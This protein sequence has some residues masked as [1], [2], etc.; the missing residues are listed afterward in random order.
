MVATDSTNPANEQPE[1]D[2]PFADV[3]PLFRAWQEGV[4]EL[5]A[6]R[7]SVPPPTP[8]LPQT[9]YD[10]ARGLADGATIKV[11]EQ[12]RVLRE[13]RE[14]RAHLRRIW[15]LAHVT[16]HQ[17]MT[18]N[19]PRRYMI[20]QC[21]A[22]IER[23][24]AL[25]TRASDR[26]PAVDTGGIDSPNPFDTAGYERQHDAALHAAYARYIAADDAL[27]ALTTP[28]GPRTPGYQE[29]KAQLRAIRKAATAARFAWGD[30]RE[31]AAKYGD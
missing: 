12:E 17:L 18:P 19:A 10:Y 2:R 14:L 5:T 4:Q 15:F 1:H 29:R 20:E 22:I 27:G 6:P 31:R 11:A 3:A 16:R 7:S 8:P 28:S 13:N 23:A 24:A 25:V 30:Y 9:V 26:W 21:Q